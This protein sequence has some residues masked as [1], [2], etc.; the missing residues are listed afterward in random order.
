MGEAFSLLRDARLV[1]R[2]S[3]RIKKEASKLRKRLRIMEFC[4]GHTHA[5]MKFGIDRLLEEAVEFVHGPGCPVCV[6]P[7]ER[8]DLALA[9]AKREEVIL[10]TYGDL[11][12]VPG[13]SGKS[14]LHARAEGAKVAGLY[15]CLDALKMAR[16]NPDKKVVF[17]AIGFETTTPQTAVL[18]KKAKEEGLKNLFVVSNHVITPAAIQH[19]LNAPELRE[20][21]RVEIDAFIGP[22]HVSTVIGT[23]PYEYFAEDF[24]KPVVI[25]GFEP[26]DLL[27]AVLM[28]VRQFLRG[29]AKVENQYGRFVRREGNLKAQRLVAEVFELRKTFRW[30]GLG[31]VPYSSL[32]LKKDWE[33]MDGEKAFEVEL[34]PPKEHPA[35]VCPKVIRGVAK[36]TDCK[37]FATVCTPQNPIGSCMVSSEGACAAYYKYRRA[38]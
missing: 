23:R 2:L 20:I 13:S 9:L 19:V 37:L 35:C 8:V 6:M 29:E 5:I 22:G 7:T 15:S 1:E 30:R 28:I 3:D 33:E 4:G 10:C 12:R 25:A 24:Q 16:E 21:G 18:L 14:L 27:Q 11:L 26:V 31:E 38:L 17:F 34:P 36:P 32:K